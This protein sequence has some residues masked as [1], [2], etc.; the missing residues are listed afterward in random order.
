MNPS[1]DSK[2][3]NNNYKNDQKIIMKIKKNNLA[4]S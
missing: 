2:G 1:K 4:E 3:K